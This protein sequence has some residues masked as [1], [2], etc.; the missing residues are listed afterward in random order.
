[1]R[2]GELN[3]EPEKELDSSGEDGSRGHN[4]PTSSIPSQGKV[5]TK[6]SKG[7]RSK[8]DEALPLYGKTGAGGSVSIVSASM[9]RSGGKK[10]NKDAPAKA[11]LDL[12]KD[13]FFDAGSSSDEEVVGNVDDDGSSE[14]E[15]EA[16]S[17][18]VVESAKRTIN[19]FEVDSDLDS[20]SE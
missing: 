14:S 8:E 16:A 19:A 4:V 17:A 10:Q 12:R 5:T 2:C 20:D 6:S 3:A 15:M 7:Q 11:K 18:Q 1:M 9:S 13:E